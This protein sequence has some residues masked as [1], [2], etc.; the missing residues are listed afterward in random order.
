MSES[1][2]DVTAVQ[3]E[4]TVLVVERVGA[5]EWITRTLNASDIKQ[6]S[7]SFH[8]LPDVNKMHKI[9][10]RKIE[11][12]AAKTTIIFL[13]TKIDDDNT[14]DEIAS[15]DMRGALSTLYGVPDTFWSQVSSR[16]QGFFGC[17]ARFDSSDH[18]IHHHYQGTWY[19]YMIKQLK[20]CGLIKA[21]DPKQF[22]SSGQ[23]IM[24][25]APIEDQV[26]KRIR[27]ALMAR[28]VPHNHWNPYWS[29]PIV[30]HT[31]IE[32]WDASV[33]DLQ[34]LVKEVEAAPL[35]IAKQV[36]SLKEEAPEV[37]FPKLHEIM[38]YALHHAEN[39][40]VAVD[41]VK[42]MK[43]HYINI[44]Q[45]IQSPD[46]NLSDMKRGTLYT[47]EYQLQILSNLQIRA[48]AYKDRMNNEITLSFNSVNQ[49]DTRISL[50]IGR[51]QLIDSTALRTIAF[52]TLACLPATLVCSI[53]GAPF[54]S[55]SPGNESKSEQFAV[56]QK[57][58]LLCA[59]ALPITALAIIGWYYFQKSRYGP[60]IYSMQH[61]ESLSASPTSMV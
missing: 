5:E 16:I 49:Y 57:A 42:S 2:K 39:L 44:S 61:H 36:S 51:S 21:L 40:Q 29:H 23:S 37:D 48:I 25:F 12:A 52:L 9:N 59:I 38:R 50:E 1:E 18:L 56:S 22:C 46:R 35:Q 19:R 11:R 55:F 30:L 60:G 58:W 14:E 15:A 31:V 41:A 24:L 33:W 10:E 20:Q 17:D 3:T 45:N 53:F 34:P 26:Q 28:D 47:L 6:M 27:E 8:S 7:T 13:S 43:D 32:I 4:D 54:F